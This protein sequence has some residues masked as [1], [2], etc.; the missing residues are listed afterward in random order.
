MAWKKLAGRFPAARTEHVPAQRPVL[1]EPSVLQKGRET[2]IF[3]NERQTPDRI[4]LGE[5]TY[6]RTNQRLSDAT[7]REI[8]L[9]AQSARVLQVLA[10]TP[11]VLVAR[12]DLI[13]RIWGDVSVTDDSLTQCVAD[14]RR[15]LADHDRALLRTMPK[16][17]Y[18]LNGVVLEVAAA[19]AAAPVD[20]PTDHAIIEPE[21]TIT[22]QLDPRDVLPTLAVMPMRSALE[23]K[24]E[25]LGIFIADEIA[26]ALGRS[27]DVNVISRLSTAQVTD[28]PGGVSD[29]RRVL[30]ADFVVSGHVLTEGDRAMLSVEFVE[31]DTQYI[32]WSE[33]VS[34]P[35]GPLL[36][37]T[38]WVAHIASHVRNA[39]MVNEVRRLRTRPLADLKLF[40]VLHG[41]VGLMHRLSPRYF[42]EARDLL[43]Y[44]IERA[45]NNPSPLAWM[46]R[47]HVLRAM[48]GWSQD[49]QKE[50][51]AAI[52]CA[53]R[54]LD[55]DSENTLALTSLGFVMTNLLHQLDDA[56]G[57]YDS[58]LVI[59]PNDAQARALRG[60]LQAFTD[61]ADD[62]KRDVER[63]LHLTPRDPHRFFYLILAAGANLSAG[64][65]TRAVT[66]A[67]ESLR[68]N[69]THVSTLRTLAAAQMGAGQADA[70]QKTVRELMRLQPDL[71]VS[72][73]QRNAPSRNFENGR[74]FAEL[75]KSAGVPD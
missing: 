33:R 41:A 59:N 28:T 46:A 15:A 16:R 68:L 54:A 5:T 60:M 14:I 47:W 31:T 18:V 43:T 74:R 63:A 37:D 45:P 69:R 71:R 1:H 19:T 10:E 13:E 24:Q 22:A 40:S 21:G 35:L 9:R 36:T 70:S 62:G 51:Q 49:V 2:D 12:D 61:H 27:E 30:N 57:Y 44:L 65:Y 42:N 3:G 66:L 48:Q 20:A 17:G 4:R 32:L 6:D 39:I 52:E 58:A 50:A 26:G 38:D 75:L 25:P 7:G 56:R 73:W 8:L 72:T 67:Q 29:L 53:E 34:L 64:D 11:G 23:G 55:I